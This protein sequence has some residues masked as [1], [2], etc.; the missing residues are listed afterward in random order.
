MYATNYIIID[1]DN[2]TIGLWVCS[3]GN[4]SSPSLY[5]CHIDTQTID[6]LGGRG[7]SKGMD[8][9][10]DTLEES[11]WNKAQMIYLKSG[12]SS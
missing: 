8:I 2:N 4:T 6:Y 7:I 1:K 12:K 9:F 5:T 10:P 3:Q 11:I